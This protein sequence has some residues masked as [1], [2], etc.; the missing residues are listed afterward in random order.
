MFRLGDL[1]HLTPG[2]LASYLALAGPDA[3]EPHTVGAYN[4]Q[5]D[6]VIEMWRGNDAPECSLVVAL[7]GTMKIIE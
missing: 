7:A 4:K 1:I 5:L 3:V 6:A 2:E